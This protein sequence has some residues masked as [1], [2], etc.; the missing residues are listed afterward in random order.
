MQHVARTPAS[1]LVCN[2]EAPRSH[3]SSSQHLETPAFKILFYSG[4]YFLHLL[5]NKI[6]SILLLLFMPTAAKNK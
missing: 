5:E 1:G 4:K 6:Y 3:S 2:K